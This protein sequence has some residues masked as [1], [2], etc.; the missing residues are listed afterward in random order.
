MSDE[1]IDV[2]AIAA[3][4]DDVEL[5]AGGTICSLTASGKSVAIVDLTRGEM[6][7]RGTVAIR[8]REA[9]RAAEI[10]AVRD[11]VNLGIPDGDIQNTKANQ[12]LLIEAIRRFR[13][14]IALISSP[15]CRHPDHADASAL[16][17]SS[18]FY[19]GLEKIET[20]RG[21]M[22]QRPWRPA[23]VLHYMQ[24]VPFI[25]TLVVDVSHVWEQRMQALLAYESQFHSTA[26]KEKAEESETYISN[27]DFLAWVEARARTYGYPTGARFGEPFL[28]HNGPIGTADLSDM[29]KTSRQF[30]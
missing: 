10:M 15:T 20:T 4:P 1:Q 12:L 17:I 30:R 25:P 3:H 23:H 21:G 2:L 5:C 16:S 8:E 13:P 29:L 9:Q 6:G 19:S 11:R 14:H 22:R 18:F 27:P 28:Y 26:Y 7:T 24:S